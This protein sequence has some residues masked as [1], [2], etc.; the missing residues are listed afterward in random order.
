MIGFL[1]TG[2]R[3]RDPT[4]LVSV[5]YSVRTDRE[6]ELRAGGCDLWLDTLRRA[7]PRTE[8][9]LDSLRRDEAWAF[10]AYWDVVMS[11]LHDPGLVI[12]G[13]AAHAMSP[14]LGQGVNLAL[15]D[16]QVLAATLDQATALEPGLA[17]FS[18]AR[19]AHLGFYQRITRWLTPFFQSSIPLAGTAR[20]TV[21]PLLSRVPFA[22]RQMLA[23][24]AGLKD[25]LVH[26]LPW[27][28]GEQGRSV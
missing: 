12:I 28:G 8:S 4:P 10:A 22:K 17:A 26:Q 2:R 5:F 25:G 14:Q 24:M 21:L 15:W 11:R 9:L 3:T 23:S 1:P 13:D 16:A 6:A 18:R 20:D 27:P 7:E 19:R